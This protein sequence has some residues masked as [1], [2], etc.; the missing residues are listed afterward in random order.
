LVSPFTDKSNLTKQ[1]KYHDEFLKWNESFCLANNKNVG[2]SIDEATML[3]VKYFITSNTSHSNLENEYLRAL[4]NKALGIKTFDDSILPEIYK[5]L[6]C[7]FRTKPGEAEDICIMSDI[8]TA[9]QNSDFIA[10]GAAIIDASL[11][12][13]I[14][15]LDMMRMPGSSHNAENIKQAI[16]NMVIL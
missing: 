2:P 15:V 3:L 11:N 4:I 5:Q 13:K 10:L 16:E 6:R 8:W 14:V 1:L 12:R 7:K 9:K